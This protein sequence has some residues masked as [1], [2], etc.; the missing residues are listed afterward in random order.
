MTLGR[1]KPAGKT[2]ISFQIRDSDESRHRAGK[3][4][5]EV[6]SGRPCSKAFHAFAG[7]SKSKFF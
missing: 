1:D 5:C 6:I 2:Q 4:I 3:Y 7:K